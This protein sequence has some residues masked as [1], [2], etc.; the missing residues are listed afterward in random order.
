MLNEQ[1]LA[2]NIVCLIVALKLNCV[3]I[4]IRSYAKSKVLSNSS[5]LYILEHKGFHPMKTKI[6]SN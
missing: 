4:F 3:E 6:P 1:F 5:F 2:W